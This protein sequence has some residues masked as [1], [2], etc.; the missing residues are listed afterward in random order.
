MEL[1]SA[2]IDEWNVAENAYAPFY[3]DRVD[4]IRTI[5]LYINE[6]NEIIYSKKFRLNIKDEMFSKNQL[7]TILK[8]NMLYNNSKFYPIYLLKFNMTLDQND[9]NAFNHEPNKFNFLKEVEYVHDILWK[10]TI[11]FFQPLNSIYIIMKVRTKKVNKGTKK[12]FI[13]N[14]KRRKR[15]RRKYI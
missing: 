5:F 12:I 1:D 6:K 13:N 2:W 11:T 10:K 4:H 8:Q 9:V 3:K 7:I 15:T 14:H